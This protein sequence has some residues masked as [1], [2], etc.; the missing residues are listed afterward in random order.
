MPTRS[1]TLMLPLSP[2]EARAVC[3]SSL[4]PRVWELVE[5]GADRLVAYEWPWRMNCQTR[6]ARLEISIQAEPAQG[7]SVR[8]EA[9]IAGFGPIPGRHLDRH[10]E[11]LE[12]RIRKRALL[13]AESN[14]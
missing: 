11:G 14:D 2:E 1:E 6:P 9:C 13:S 3:C 10:L 5:D 8:L 7:A 12:A 4:S